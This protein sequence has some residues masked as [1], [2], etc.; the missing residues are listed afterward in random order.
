MKLCR[1]AYFVRNSQLRQI[2]GSGGVGRGMLDPPQSESTT[3]G[4]LL[5]SQRH[6][7]LFTC[8]RCQAS[9]LAPVSTG[10][11]T[12]IRFY[13]VCQRILESCPSLCSKLLYKMCQEFLDMTYKLR[14]NWIP[15]LISNL[16]LNPLSSRMSN[17]VSS[18]P[19]R[20]LRPE[21]WYP[22]GY[23]SRLNRD[24]VG[25]LSKLNRYSVGYLSRLNRYSVGYLSKLNWYTV[26]Y[27]SRL[28]LMRS[29]I[30]PN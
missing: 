21:F 10:L 12:I 1:P 24:S 20:Y 3:P 11:L 16:S 28:N 18:L 9:L 8:V 26:G 13:T 5:A 2:P 30:F 4:R 14:M 7:A 23:L 25:Y 19:D 6:T 29:D 17:A 27:L 22:G 15:C